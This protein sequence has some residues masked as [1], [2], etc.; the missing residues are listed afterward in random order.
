V[1]AF[2]CLITRRFVRHGKALIRHEVLSETIEIGLNSKRNSTAEIVITKS[3]E[4]RDKRQKRFESLEKLGD[5]VWDLDDRRDFFWHTLL[6]LFSD[7]RS[8]GEF[9]GNGSQLH[10][11]FLCLGTCLA[12]H[13]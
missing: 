12:A 6:L 8:A 11:R 4:L 10:G 13:F 1:P 5:R 7:K 2:R 9:L 3:G